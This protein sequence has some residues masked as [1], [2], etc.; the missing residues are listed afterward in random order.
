MAAINALATLRKLVKGVGEPDELGISA[1]YFTPSEK[2]L[3]VGLADKIQAEVDERFMELPT[4]ADGIPIRPKEELWNKDTG[5]HVEAEHVY[6]VSSTR[7]Y[8]WEEGPNKAHGIFGSYPDYYVHAKP[9][10]V[11][12]VL[13]D[14]WKEALDYAKSDIWRNPDEVFAER[15]DEIR[16]LMGKGT[17]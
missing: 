3:F 10:T 6:A 15:A 7:V 13:R 16:K 2:E 17:L 1:L 12:D 9:R 4:A 5:E 8:I 14:V 11:E